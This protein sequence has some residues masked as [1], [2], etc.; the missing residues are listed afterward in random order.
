VREGSAIA[1]SVRADRLLVADEDHGVLRRLRIPLDGSTAEETKL[2]GAPAQVL[3][4]DG[5]VLVTVRSPGL[6]LVLRDEPGAP[7][8]ELS[9]V[10]LPEDAWGLAVTPDERTALVTSAWTAKVSAIDLA[11]SKL[12]WSAEVGREPRA[13]VVRGD[14]KS[15]YV[16][17]LTSAALTRIDDLDGPPKVTTIRLPAAPLRAP[18]GTSIPASLGWSLALSPDGDRLFAPRHAL[19]AL[20]KNSWFGAATVDVLFTATDTPVAPRRWA[21]MPKAK[22]ALAEQLVSGQDVELPAGIGS[23]FT[24]PRAALV[25]RK[26][27]SLLVA[28]EGDDR[29]VEL[30]AAAIEPAMAVLATYPLGTDV[31]PT[32]PVAGKGGAPAGMAL[33][34]DEDTLYVLCRST[35]DVAEVRLASDPPATALPKITYVRLAEDPLGPDGSLGR[36]LFYNATDGLTSGG[37][38]CA[39]C[40][41][42]GRDDGHVWHEAKFS[43]ADG[44]N[45]NFVGVAENVPVEAHARG[46][47][48]RTPL[49]AGHLRTEGPFGWHAQNPNV[50]AR[51]R[52][53]FGLHRWGGLPKHQPENVDARAL[54]LV[55]FLRDGL[56]VPPRRGGELTD[57]ERRGKE[58]FLSGEAAC[59]SCHVPES[60]YSNQIAMPL[61]PRPTRAGYDEDPRRDYKTP[62][63][64]SLAGRAPYFHDGHAAS[65]EELVE[66]NENWMGR[67]KHLDAE[68]R[69]ALVAFLRTL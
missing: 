59:S 5:R 2:P 11:S 39:G 28:G 34:A 4:L 42:E 63:L 51:L 6:L 18:P 53:G 68:G 38:A 8:T 43:T 65:L 33:S 16:S 30:D 52:E 17:H 50:V 37:L 61:P 14:G 48:R 56:V 49:L 58:I 15:A 27:R 64:M 35:Y 45:G 29:V 25:R 1:R 32:F 26:T 57:E 36:R 20:G 40:H 3:A 41:P 55:P 21:G 46:F 19:G 69:K 23:P 24:Q 44:E 12:S 7:M 22:S 47:A 13:V 62:Q 66:K 67:T 9:R 54:R 31:S 60:G 10:A